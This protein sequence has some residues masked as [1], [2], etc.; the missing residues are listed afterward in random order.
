[1]KLLFKFIFKYDFSKK[2]IYR[3]LILFFSITISTTLFVGTL[4]SSD[5]L[6][7]TY[8]AYMTKQF[9]NYNVIIESRDKHKKDFTSDD[10]NIKEIE[11][12]S[13][14]HLLSL[15]D[16]KK[17]N[18]IG[19]EKKEFNNNFQ[20]INKLEVKEASKDLTGF[21]SINTSERFKIGL[22][23]KIELK[24]KDSFFNVTVVGIVSNEFVFS[25]DNEKQYS[26]IVDRE[27]LKLNISDDQLYNFGYL[28]VISNDLD[29]W[30]SY[31]NSSNDSYK[32]Q[33]C[34][35]EAEL[36]QS[37][38]LISTP[39]Y[40]ML[41]VVIVCSVFV[42][43]N[44]YKLLILDRMPVLGTFLSQG[45]SYNK[46]IFS[47]LGECAIFGLGAGAV[48]G[49]VGNF[50]GK[51]IIE[52]SNPLR[53]YNIFP[54]VVFQ[55]KYIGVAI[56]FSVFFSIISALLPVRS[57]KKYSLKDIL[58]E[59]LEANE[60]YKG[61]HFII[62]IILIIISVL[63]G[64]FFDNVGAL[65]FISLLFM[66][67]GIIMCVP[68]ICK[69][70]TYLISLLHKKNEGIGVL[71]KS[72]ISASKITL[73]SIKVLTATLIIIFMLNSIGNKMAS[74][75]KVGYR[76]INFNIFLD[77]KDERLK[78]V[79]DIITSDDFLIHETGNIK[80]YLNDDKKKIVS[81]IYV[82]TEKYK[83]FEN[84]IHF[85]NKER[86][87][88]KL[89]SCE[90]GIIISKQVAKTNNI[91]N[92]DIISISTSD[93]YSAELVVISICD[94]IMWR[95]GNYNIIT[96]DTAKKIFGIRYPSNYYI[97]FD[98]NDR[99]AVEYYNNKLKGYDV[100]IYTKDELIKYEEQNLKQIASMMSMLSTT[101]L[102]CG[103]LAV[104][105]N[106]LISAVYKRKE[107]LGLKVLGLEEV[108]SVLILV[109][110]NI[111]K[112]LISF[113]IAIPI[114][115]L[116]II[117][118]SNFMSFLSFEMELD[119]PIGQMWVIFLCVIIGYI[120][121]GLFS[122][123]KNSKVSIREMQRY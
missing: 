108:N 91:E 45:S 94:P 16:E 27:K 114:S 60:K 59:D 102:I 28:N 111:Y 79:N 66:F 4:M 2:N 56:V 29:N 74:I 30:I 64:L 9:K 84:Y 77:V 68:A 93:G 87:L 103:L 10:V 92:G 82:D 31:F 50:L 107:I 120:L 11:N 101:I 18:V 14:A 47:L 58:T 49:I 41:A 123:I 98:M 118:M 23:D 117:Y 112:V 36:K 75:V 39:L 73:S 72:D 44:S 89:N 78:D 42:I 57:I 53:E 70:M 19:M 63:C 96:L 55:G 54:D 116:I 8:N 38:S 48:S 32:A 35:D 97:S 105:G 71:I 51:I 67:I 7:K 20:F 100:D 88:D 52:S 1:M 21:I 76:V 22:G 106:A 121:I 80:T 81:L 90:N 69:A 85:E 86:E 65:I 26:I 115:K 13:I 40:F 25:N 119:F 33:K 113:G 5:L 24:T 15:N 62:G 6:V 17:I 122:S 37:I 95:G 3:T 99:E 34:F 46:L 83:V 110:E 61:N 104:G 43:I 109:L 12:F